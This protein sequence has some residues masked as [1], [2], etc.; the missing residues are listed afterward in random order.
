[1]QNKKF[2]KKERKNRF[3]K[4]ERLIMLIR[5]IVSVALVFFH[6]FRC[7]STVI[8]FSQGCDVLYIAQNV[9]L[10]TY[11]LQQLSSILLTI[12]TFTSQMNK[13]V[14]KC[15]LCFS[16]YISSQVTYI[17]C[18]SKHKDAGVRGSSWTSCFHLL[19]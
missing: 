7:L 15:V 2:K 3:N 8:N 16:G 19:H 5:L 1:M 4:W 17:S 14:G 12:Q 6:I 11:V 10:P 18:W 9:T 13:D